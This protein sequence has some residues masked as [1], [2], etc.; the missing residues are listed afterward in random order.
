MNDSQDRYSS[1]QVNDPSSIPADNNHAGSEPDSPN[2]PEAKARVDQLIDH[3][4]QQIALRALDQP[5]PFLLQQMV[6]SLIDPRRAARIAMVECFSQIGKPATPY[7]LEGIAS[8]PEPVV[9]RACCN[10]LT[11]IGDPTSVDGLIEALLHDS[12]IGVKSA[13]AGTLAKVGAPAFDSLRAVLASD[14]ASES[15]KGHAAWAIASMSSEVS[16]RLYRH[17]SDPSPAVRTAV[18]GA[19][20]QLAQKQQVAQPQ[21]AQEQAAQIQTGRSQSDGRSLGQQPGQPQTG[22][23]QN[24][25]RQMGHLK[26]GAPPASH[27]RSESAHK[28]TTMLTEALN[29]HSPE[30]R[31][32]AATNLARLNCQQAYQPLIA[33]L[34][35]RQAEVRK[36]AALALAKLGNPDAIEAIT[37]LQRDVETSVQRVAAMAVKQLQASKQ[38]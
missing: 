5:D 35:D 28:A 31:I 15:C 24:G 9:R 32:E 14:Q 4:N 36:A 17:M 26:T 6:H 19:I 34:K 16:E 27:Y 2:S 13:A 11:N 7:L 18:I 12:D 30:V 21:T 25:Q 23:Q 20:A 22:Q 8:H 1:G 29:D 3:V 33:C 10:A 37:A 38:A